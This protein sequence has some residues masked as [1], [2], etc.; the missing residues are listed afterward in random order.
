M[1][2]TTPDVRLLHS[3]PLQSS[4]DVPDLLRLRMYPGDELP[5]QL[6]RTSSNVLA[7]WWDGIN[8]VGDADLQLADSDVLLE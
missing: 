8:P 4:E 2:R 7:L 6:V 5:V 1:T 3:L